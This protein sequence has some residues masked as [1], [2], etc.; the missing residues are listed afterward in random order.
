MR[1]QPVETASS[2]TLVLVDVVG[3][4]L[5]F[6]LAH[7]VRF[8]NLEVVDNTAILAIA[9]IVIGANY[10]L[11]CYSSQPSDD[12]LKFAF[13]SL[14]AAGLAMLFSAIFVYLLGPLR[15]T[16]TFGRGILFG[17]MILYALWSFAFRYGYARLLRALHQKTR[18]LYVGGNLPHQNFVDSWESFESPGKLVVL[19]GRD[20]AGEIAQM[21]PTG[22]IIEELGLLD[23]Y[24]S[25][26]WDGVIVASE[27]TLPKHVVA[28]LS[29]MRI[30]GANIMKIEHFYELA[31][32]R[33]PVF[34]L[35]DNWFL[36][37][38]GFNLINDRLRLF[39]KRA[40]DLV[41][42]LLL[43]VIS[44][45]IQLVV[46]ILVRTDSPGPILFTQKRKG[47]GGKVFTIIKF[48]TMYEGS[49]ANGAEWA[50]EGDQRITRAGRFLRT[51]RLDE[52]PQLFNVIKGEMSFIGPRPERPE[53]TDELEALI[54]YY[55][56]RYLV[57][58]GITGWAQVLYPYGS[59]VEDA[60]NK[61]MYDLYYIKNQ[62][63]ILDLMIVIKTIKVVLH[64]SGR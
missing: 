15:F 13:Q 35:N 10:L 33:V 40:G 30:H 61:L 4:Y 48:R 6:Y 42:A 14:L 8:G 2:L 60:E 11:N 24:A 50:R 44:L 27:D 31:W 1:L 17:A 20:A 5:C 49:E 38:Q 16:E 53:F 55:D 45:P 36:Y 7:A 47:L 12:A 37:S 57:R 21:L 58:P 46:A 18:W 43:L 56:L 34:S 63:I 9:I 23:E 52:L 39:A 41:F 3:V 59:S 64:V 29:Q 25:E 28:T 32:N 19:T 51:S 54:P 62:S 22:C 26:T